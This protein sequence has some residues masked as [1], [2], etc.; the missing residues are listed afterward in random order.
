MAFKEVGGFKYY[1]AWKLWK[2]GDY[3]IGEYRGSSTDNYGKSNWHI[4]IEDLQ[5]EDNSNFDDKKPDT[6]GAALE[7]GMTIGLNSCGSLDMKMEQ[8]AE[9]EKVKIVYMGEGNINN[10]K[11]KFHGKLFHKVELF[12]DSG[13]EKEV[14][15]A[16]ETGTNFGE[17]I[18]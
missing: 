14:A 12:V 3:I 9:G 1:K 18:L 13:E 8:I 11:S 2:E 4:A 5:M 16:E 15:A 10:P 7:A 6:E 17:Q